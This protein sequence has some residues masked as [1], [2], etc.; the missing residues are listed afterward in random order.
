V[1]GVQTCALPI[2]EQFL[3][4]HTNRR[5]DGYGGSVE[6]RSRF[7]RE[8]AEATAAAIGADRLGIRL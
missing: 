2:F 4:P 3:N 1:T 5:G 7:V 8:V 6:R